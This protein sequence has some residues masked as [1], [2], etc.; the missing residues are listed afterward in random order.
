MSGYPQLYLKYKGFLDALI[1]R[2][3]E[4]LLIRTCCEEGMI[5]HSLFKSTQKK[6]VYNSSSE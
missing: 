2:R 5:Y 3:D 6:I 4:F 1:V